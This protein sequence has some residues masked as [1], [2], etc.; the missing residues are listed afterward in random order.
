MCFDHLEAEQ[1]KQLPQDSTYTLR[2]I[3]PIPKAFVTTYR[4]KQEGFYAGTS[5]VSHS[6]PD[7]IQSKYETTQEPQMKWSVVQMNLGI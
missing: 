1:K 4:S 6:V 3:L 7:Q 5:S 2:H